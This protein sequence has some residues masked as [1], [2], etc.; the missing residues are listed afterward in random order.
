MVSSRFLSF[1]LSFLFARKSE[2]DKESEVALIKSHQ[3]SQQQLRSTGQAKRK[4]KKVNRDQARK[5]KTQA[6]RLATS[7]NKRTRGVDHASSD[8]DEN[9]DSQ[10]ECESSESDGYFTPKTVKGEEDTFLQQLSL[11]LKTAS[12]AKGDNCKMQHQMEEASSKGCDTFKNQESE[13]SV[14]NEQDSVHQTR[15]DDSEI[16]N[17]AVMGITS[18]VAMFDKLR[19]DMT[20][21]MDDLNKKLQDIQQAPKQ[22]VSETVIEECKNDITR[23]IEV[24]LEGDR[25]ELDKVKQDLR[26]FKFRNRTLTN[27]VQHMSVEI[28]DLKQRME[29]IELSNSRNAVSLTGFYMTNNKADGIIELEKFFNDS[30]GLYV[31]IDDYFRVGAQE[32]RMTVIFLQ[33]QQQKRDVMRFKSYLKNVKNKDNRPLY[34]NEYV[35][36]GVQERRRHDRDIFDINESLQNPQAVEYKKGKLTI[37]GQTYQPKVQPPT[38]AQ[39]VDVNPKDLD[40][41]LKLP[42]DHG[43]TI[44]QDKSIFDSYIASVDSHQEIRELYMKIKWM[45]PAARHIV[46]AYWIRGET[47]YNQDFC[48]DDE[49]AAGRAVLNTMLFHQMENRVIFI[50]QKYGGIKMGTSRF[51]CYKEAAKIAMQKHSWNS[52]LQINQFLNRENDHSR[53]HDD[54]K[55]QTQFKEPYA[56]DIPPNSIPQQNAATTSFRGRGQSY[57]R[58]GPYR[59]NSYRGPNQRR[60]N[61]RD[62]HRQRGNFHQPRPH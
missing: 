13:Q 17:P 38:P 12:A 39:L 27:V 47:F 22:E 35:P 51:K 19:K 14:V 56:A 3:S 25:K 28:S 62:M 7:Q 54:K 16:Q 30:M 57:T 49:P 21:G 31:S 44:T 18:V 53:I 45:E 37:Q 24:S 29:N 20:Q 1:F 15:M 2:Q 48:D 55:Q 23:A 52:K 42:L 8:T 36:A 46:C 5:L 59:G 9:N 58:R 33:T 26:Y 60:P 43:G 4:R 6:R 50:A 10:G 32:P 61:Q 34:I 11:Q 40:R 41:V